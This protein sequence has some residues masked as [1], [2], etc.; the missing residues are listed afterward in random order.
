MCRERRG[1]C[2]RTRQFALMKGLGKAQ[3]KG[4][5]SDAHDGCNRSRRRREQ[6]RRIVQATWAPSL[7][8]DGGVAHDV[9]F[10]ALSS[11]TDSVL[12]ADLRPIK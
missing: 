1:S 4:D 8:S 10:S 9:H 5:E 11:H 6:I 3:Q 12:E 2:R 7:A